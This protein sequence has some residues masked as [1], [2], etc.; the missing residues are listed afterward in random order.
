MP[1][2]ESPSGKITS[3]AT[4]SASSTLSRTAASYAPVSP[5]SLSRSHGGDVLAVDLLDHRPVLVAGE[6]P[7]VELGVHEGVEVLAVVRRR[8]GPRGCRT[9]R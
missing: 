8:A 6:E 3:P 9:R 1:V 7:L 5:A 2:T 4:P